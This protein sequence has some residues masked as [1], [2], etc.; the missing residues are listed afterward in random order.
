VDPGAGFAGHLQIADVF[1]EKRLQ[2]LDADFGKFLV[3][4]GLVDPELIRTLLGRIDEE[5]AKRQV[6]RSDGRICLERDVKHGMKTTE[7][8][9]Y[10]CNRNTEKAGEG[11]G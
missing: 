7:C 6:E 2:T 3:G 5:I 11:R 9:G 8:T 4:A 1:L 10:R